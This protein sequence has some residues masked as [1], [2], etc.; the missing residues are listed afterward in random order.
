MFRLDHKCYFNY[1]RKHGMKWQSLQACFE[2]EFLSII[3]C[4][5]VT[6]IYL[7]CDLDTYSKDDPKSGLQTPR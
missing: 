1:T 2:L 7:N 5:A 3:E 6:N 4:L